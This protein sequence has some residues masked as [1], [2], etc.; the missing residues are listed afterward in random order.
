MQGH[1][2]SQDFRVLSLQSYD[3]VLGM[4]WLE[5][6]SPMKV[7]WGNKWMPIPYQESSVL[8]Q[9]LTSSVPDDLV[10]QIL[11]VQSKEEKPDST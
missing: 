10:V 3:M 7:H 6:F 5:H 1:S 2:F 11:S 4:D 8:L 9:G